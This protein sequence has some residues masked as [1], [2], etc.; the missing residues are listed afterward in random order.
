VSIPN[1]GPEHPEPSDPGA[2]ESPR[3]GNSLIHRDE[4]FVGEVFA[5]ST[6]ATMVTH[7]FGGVRYALS[8]PGG[9]TVRRPPAEEDE[10]DA[11]D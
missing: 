5:A 11:R 7:R 2:T 3:W 9:T 8:R 10:S 4:P 1:I 6:R